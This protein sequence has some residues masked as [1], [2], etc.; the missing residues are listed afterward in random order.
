MS[1]PMAIKN[2]WL[3]AKNLGGIILAILLQNARNLG[4]Q[5]SELLLKFMGATGWRYSM[6]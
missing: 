6:G 1:Y 2:L 5:W 3:W 4:C